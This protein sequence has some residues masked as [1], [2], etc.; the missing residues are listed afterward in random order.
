MKS[1]YRSKD[2]C[3]LA[4]PPGRP[5][6][7]SEFNSWSELSRIN[8]TMYGRNFPSGITVSINQPLPNRFAN[9]DQQMR[10]DRSCPML[11]ELPEPPLFYYRNEATEIAP[12]ASRWHKRR[13]HMFDGDIT[14]EP[15][16]R[17]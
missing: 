10:S 9:S 15:N 2:K 14:S 13:A 11:Y 6:V 16:T 4:E 7:V 1:T 3:V 8:P 17:C 12:A 5:P